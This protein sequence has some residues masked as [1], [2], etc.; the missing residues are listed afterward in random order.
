MKLTIY[1]TSIYLVITGLGAISCQKNKQLD[2]GCDVTN[3]AI[4]VESGNLAGT[5]VFN[6]QALQGYKSYQNKFLI[7]YQDPNCADCIFTMVVCNENI[8]TKDILELKNDPIISLKVKFSG[9]RKPICDK[10]ISPGINT[11]ENI[12]LTTIKIE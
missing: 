2:C 4:I 3:P 10:L 12:V 11:Y 7:A 8:L 6:E 1:L 5:I 9:Y